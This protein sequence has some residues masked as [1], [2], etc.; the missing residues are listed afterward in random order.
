MKKN[1]I[2]KTALE[3]RVPWENSSSSDSAFLF[4][5]LIDISRYSRLHK[6]N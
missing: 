5:K 1:N 3:V 2:F 6:V 4:A